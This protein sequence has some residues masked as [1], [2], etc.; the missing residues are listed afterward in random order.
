M[1]PAAHW[2]VPSSTLRFVNPAPPISL[3]LSLSLDCSVWYRLEVTS[4]VRSRASGYGENQEPGGRMTRANPTPQ[5][6]TP[7]GTRGPSPTSPCL[8]QLLA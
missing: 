7:A 4:L 8:E 6:G 5:I 1:P 2:A 3:S